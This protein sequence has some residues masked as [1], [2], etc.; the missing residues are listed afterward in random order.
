MFDFLVK[1]KI[2]SAF[3]NNKRKHAFRNMESMESI[4]I[5]FSYKDW[6]EI[7]SISKD[8]EAKGKKVILWT[9]KPSQKN[10]NN[11]IFPSNIRV[12]DSKEISFT[13]ILSSTVLDEYKALLYDTLIDL[14]TTANKVFKYLLVNTSAEFS[15]GISEP[16]HRIYDFII[17]REDSNTLQE[18]YNQIKFYLNNIR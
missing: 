2:D 7:E 11:T 3:K 6:S 8:L 15:I 9:I 12:I 17:H 10:L 5:L 4:L 18:T 14:T 16:E 1:Y 13:K